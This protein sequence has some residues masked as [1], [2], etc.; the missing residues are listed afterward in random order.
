MRVEGN[1]SLFPEP[2]PA[3]MVI[4]HERSGTHFLMNSLAACYG[5]VTT[6]WIDFD[7]PPFEINFYHL[8]EVRDLLL[9]AADR[10]MANIMKSHHAVDFFRGALEMIT[11]RYVL[12]VICRHPAPVMLSFW[13]FMHQWQWV[14]GPRA[15]DPLSFAQAEPCGR[16]MRYQMRQS[17]NLL[18]RWAAH[19]DG[20]LDAAGEHP[21]VVIVRYEDLD[22]DYEGTMLRFQGH[23]GRPPRQIVRPGRDR[24]VTLPGHLAPEVSD[25]PPDIEAL[26][27]LCRHQVASTMSRLGYE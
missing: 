3:A 6:P 10:P 15:A 22:A 27:A 17:V 1:F 24:N 4:S 2:R 12:F 21:G 26:H 16:M 7:R 25:S 23:L 13:R 19:V 14:E 18:A 9:G 11:K 20:W 8:P 5:Y